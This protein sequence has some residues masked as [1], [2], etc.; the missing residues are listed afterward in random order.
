[1]LTDRIPVSAVD[2]GYMRRRGRI[3]AI[4]GIAVLI[5]VLVVVSVAAPTSDQPRQ[6]SYVSPFMGTAS[7][8]T[9][10]GMSAM[11][12]DG[13]PGQEFPGASLPFGMLQWSPDTNT[14]NDPTASYQAAPGPSTLVGFSLIHN[15]GIQ[16]RF[17]PF[18]PLS[19][20]VTESP[21]VNPARYYG[22]FRQKDA[23]ASP[24]FYKVRLASGITTEITATA[25][26]GLARFSFPTGDPPTLL[27]ALS[28][29]DRAGPAE[30]QVQA[31]TR[32]IDG[33][34]TANGIRVY[35][36][37]QFNQSF[38]RY[39]TYSGASLQPGRADVAGNTIGGWLGF[40]SA[41]GVVQAS[42]AVS[43]VSVEDAAAN[44]TAEVLRPHLT[45]GQA[46]Q[47]A[48]AKWAEVLDRFAVSG[49]STD[50]LR[51][52]Y[53]ALYDA[54]LQPNLASDDDGRYMGWDG[55]V[56]QVPDGH[57]LYTNISSW[58]MERSQLAFLAT[59]F[60]HETADMMQSLVDA[61]EQTGGWARRAV[62]GTQVEDF[63]VGDWALP[64][65]AYQLGVR[66]F[67]ARAAL[68][69]ELRTATSAVGNPVRSDLDFY[70]QHGWIPASSMFSAEETIDDS[71]TDFVISRFARA[72]GESQVAQ[73]L[74]SRSENWRNVFDPTLVSG[75]ERG[76]V[77]SRQA[78]G[79]FSPGW[80]PA[81]GSCYG[82]FEEATSAQYSF[83]ALQDLSGVANGMGGP[84]QAVDRLD[85]LLQV[86]DAGCLSSHAWLGNEPDLALP[87]LYDWFGRPSRTQATVR[88]VIDQLYSPAPSGLPGNDDWGALTTYYV[89]CALGLYPALPGVPGL[90]LASP[91]FKKVA[92]ELENGSTLT[93]AAAGNPA[94]SPYVSNLTV[95]G[96][97]SNSA[98]LPL[99]EVQAGGSLRFGL[100][101]GATDWATHPA[102]S[103]APPS[104]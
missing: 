44:L 87:W 102:A 45:F 62:I 6:E 56:R 63:D 89:W 43:Y 66:G 32:S 37:A 19:E 61:Y 29:S 55:R 98:W 57:A 96:R 18:L 93:I 48:R 52:F 83:G 90:A 71:Y 33:Y 50:Q 4:A 60:P 64:A 39:G 99:A 10:T 58:D 82:P 8:A 69:I 23:E 101:A 36:V 86:L 59:F 22:H 81:A 80:S 95:D 49:G 5:T 84:S 79:A 51:T 26:A 42:V 88:R 53:S 78:S 9:E 31:D 35:F 94:I 25:R 46:L 97:A 21:A 41:G 40:K 92:I 67:D 103:D 1:M 65:T 100:T 72:L 77:W 85:D 28:D 38:A 3:G 70:E 34:V 13:Q 17:V 73:S 27:L 16:Y 74:G 68:G 24:G 7:S 104:F 47:D 11:N 2:S 75:S 76:F 54:V 14:D 15:S 91:L 12:S 30:L 20:P